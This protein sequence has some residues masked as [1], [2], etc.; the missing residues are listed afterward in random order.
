MSSKPVLFRVNNNLNIGGI[1][2]RLRL[3]LPLLCNDYSVHVVTYR[4]EG[5][6]ADELRDKGIS[7]HHVPIPSKWSPLGIHALAKLLRKE[8]ARIVHTH[9]FGGNISGILAASLAKVPVR[10][11]QVH[12]RQQ[13]WYGKTELHRKKQ[14]F[15]EYCVHSLFSDAVLFPSQ[16]ALDYFVPHCPVAARKLEVLYNGVSLPQRGE[17]ESL[18][19]RAMLDIRP[20]VK[21]LGFVGRTADS[22]GLDFAFS[23]MRRLRE[24]SPDYC[25]VVVGDV[26]KSETG[27]IFKVEADK[28]GGK[29]IHCVGLRRNV[30]PF[31]NAFDGF[32]F[33]S[34]P[35]SE[36]L[37]GVVLEAASLGLPILSRHNDTVR[38]IA[39]FYPA[40]HFMDDEDD[41]LEAVT[42][43]FALPP[44]SPDPIRKI[45]SVEAMA[46]RTKALYERLLRGKA[47][48]GTG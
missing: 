8:N 18:D 23:F 11:G 45:F 5:I 2:S 21:I 9:S 17:G 3:V 26:E 31:Y 20:G 15:E 37:P 33:P 19:L 35:W 42:S 7:V 38:E 46:A 22:K 4:T 40:V 39:G 10:I 48:G 24:K 43:L 13:H 28:L 25:L 32:F 29:L 27:R 6:L 14:M 44:A 41:P 36:A 12:T 34:E 16:A 30:A 1:T 47:G